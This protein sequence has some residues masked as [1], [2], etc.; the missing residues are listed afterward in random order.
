[1]SRR[2]PPA[3]PAPM[4]AEAQSKPSS[5][6]TT[7]GAGSVTTGSP[8][9]GVS[10]PAGRALAAGAASAPA[11][12][13]A[14]ARRVMRVETFMTASFRGGRGLMPGTVLEGGRREVYARFT[15]GST[16]VR[17]A[18]R[19][20]AGARAA[21]GSPRGWADPAG[22]PQA[23]GGARDACAGA[24]QDGVGRPVGRGVVG[25]LLAAE[26]GE[27][28]AALCVASA[29]RARRGSGSDRDAR[30][31]LCPGACGW[32]RRCGAR[33][34]AAG[35]V[36]G[37]R[38]AGAVGG[39]GGGGAGGR[40]ERREARADEPFAA[41][42]V[43]RLEELRLRAAELAID[44][45]LAAGRHA[46]VIG[47]LDALVAAHPLHERLY[48]Q[49]MLALYR[50]NRQSEALAAYQAARAGLVEEIGVEP[51]ADLQRLHAQ[52]LAHDPALD[53]PAATASQPVSA[54]RARPRQR[55]RAAL[56]GAALLVLAGVLAFGMI[57]VLEPDGL[58]G[59]DENFVGLIDPGGGRITKKS[60][61][62]AHPTA[63]VSGG[64]SVWIAD[65]ADG[66]VTRIDR[67][68]AA[69]VKIPTG[70]APTALA[71]GGGSLWVAD[72]ESRNVLQVDP[73]SNKVVQP[74]EVGNAPRALAV[75]AGKVWVASGV[76]GRIR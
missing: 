18:R 6:C 19:G 4:A 13:L 53:L 3:V 52:I 2:S 44:A 7:G 45:D 60:K 26:R 46:E 33:R 16:G 73:G 10:G 9:F 64:G 34:A 57:R 72:S 59:I 24:R 21:R 55:S 29:T 62:G 38:G 22:P 70:G 67:G 48:A 17:V 50:A 14:A 32:R 61:A 71:L 35:G 63:A 41:P 8:V 30:S 68:R 51:G 36:A 66:T 43:R 20:R 49:R 74:F 15:R 31:R 37:A 42:E 27:D 75:A 47:E 76:D 54:S 1:M 39:G 25:G 12:R 23:A 65:E 40:G 11:M 5:I 56:V 28:G 58:P 69:V